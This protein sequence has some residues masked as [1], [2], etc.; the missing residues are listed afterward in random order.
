MV[1]VL[2]YAPDHSLPGQIPP[3][4]HFIR[5]SWVPEPGLKRRIPLVLARSLVTT[6]TELPHLTMR[7]N[8]QCVRKSSKESSKK[9]IPY[10][11]IFM[12]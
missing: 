11:I 1:R 6:P 7:K 8:T 12:G 3:G 4:T 2:H 5:T 9:E 10:Q